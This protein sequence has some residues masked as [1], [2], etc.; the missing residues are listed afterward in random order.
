MNNN[1]QTISWDKVLSSFDLSGLSSDLSNKFTDDLKKM[2]NL[3]PDF[4]NT[5]N[6]LTNP[7]QMCVL[8]ASEVYERY[9]SKSSKTNEKPFGL[10]AYVDQ[11]ADGTKVMYIAE[12]WYSDNTFSKYNSTT[13]SDNTIYWQNLRDNLGPYKQLSWMSIAHELGHIFDYIIYG[14]D[15]FNSFSGK[16]KEWSAEQWANKMR[17]AFGLPINET[18]TS[19]FGIRI[20]WW[21]ECIF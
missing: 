4:F 8:P 20:M 7:I 15:E 6:K 19:S 13:R 11:N 21:W 10:G 17:E 12:E 14:R 16:I 1:C 2:Y 5:L 18:G 3:L 9:Y